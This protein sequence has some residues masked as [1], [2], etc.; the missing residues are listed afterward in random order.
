MLNFLQNL[1]VGAS[2]C[3]YVVHLYNTLEC[4]KKELENED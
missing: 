1:S 4:N 2:R 3:I